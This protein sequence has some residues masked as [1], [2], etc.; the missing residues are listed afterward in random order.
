MLIVEI[1]I[2][3]VLILFNGFMAMS[4][5]AVVSAR[6][7]R[8]KSRAE[9]GQRGA[10]RALALSADPGRFLSTVQIGITL[11][12]VLSGA[13]SGATLGTRLSDWLVMQGVSEGVA[14]PL[15]VG[16]VVALITYV[17]L[18]V[19]E[20]V[21]KQIA[22]KNAE[23]IAI[24]VAPIMGLLSRITLPLVW[25]LDVSGRLVLALLGQSAE[26]SQRVTDEEI[27]TLIA[28]AETSGTIASDERRMIAG[29]M[30]LADR[31]TRAIM[32][33]RGEIDWLD[34]TADEAALADDVRESGHSL[35]PA[36]EGSIDEIAGVVKLRDL[37]AVQLSGEALDIRTH[38]LPAPIVHDMADALDVLSVLREAAVPMALVHDEHGHFEGIVTP[39]DILEAIA[40]LFRADAEEGEMDIVER[41][42]GSWLLP[43]SM[44]ADE[45]ADHLGFALPAERTY[46]TLAGFLLNEF[47]HLP[48]TG[49]STDAMGWRFEIMD[50]D[51]RRIDRVLA[52]KLGEVAE[53]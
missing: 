13:F 2:L 22:L 20:L 14:N 42:D 5:L 21:P 34:L 6:P 12:G 45:M 51:N 31:K 23:G 26:S 15:G 9:Q 10:A 32:T 40:G 30:R 37:L 27:R 38:V 33:P 17:S 8:L 50:L 46:T 1:V 52:T 39:S 35:L 28:E 18:I 53:A 25:L 16:L 49:E 48:K 29:V 24:R 7:A 36:G 3:F 11:V 43:G 4:E 44:P 47:T 41:A 19:G